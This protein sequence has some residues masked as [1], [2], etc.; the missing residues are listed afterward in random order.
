MPIAR[1]YLMLFLSL[2]FLIGC[3][4]TNILDKVGVTSLIGYDIGQEEKIAVTGVIREINPD[5]KS[6][7]QVF[8]TENNTLL[9][10]KIK[11]NRELSEQ[12]SFGQTRVITFGEDLARE[13]LDYFIHSNL[14]NPN[15]N[16]NLYMAVIEGKAADLLENEYKDIE[17]IGQHIFRLIEQNNKQKFTTTTTLHIIADDYY[18]NGKEM[19]MPIL[20]R[21]GDLVEFSAIGIFKGGKMV[22]TLPAKDN[23]FVNVIRENF[24]MGVYETVLQGDGNLNNRNSSLNEMR[25]TFDTIKSK[26]EI[27]LVDASKPEFDLNISMK[28]RVLE[29]SPDINFWQRESVAALEKDIEKKLKNEISRVIGHTQE[30]ESDIFGFGEKYRSTVRHSKLTKEKWQKKYKIMKVNVN[31]DFTILRNGVFE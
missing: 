22:S 2:I 17:D 20:K 15:I 10:N 18:S 16:N 6:K 3:V 7:V 25:L 13:G 8:T 1:F 21:D 31:I 4:R 27:K 26:R 11:T 23:F 5:F 24:N 14:E 12:V 30:V 9:G 19:S 29:V 28:S